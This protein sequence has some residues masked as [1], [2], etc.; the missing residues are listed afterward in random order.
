MDSD[1]EEYIR[2]ASAN[3]GFSSGVTLKNGGYYRSYMD[4]ANGEKE[5]TFMYKGSIKFSDSNSLRSIAL[6]KEIPF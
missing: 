1:K 4:I 6:I 2:R 3:S 5:I